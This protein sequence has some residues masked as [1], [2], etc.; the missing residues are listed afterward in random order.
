[1]SDVIARWERTAAIFSDRLHEVRDDQWGLP[2][3]CSEWNVR[4]LVDH[5]VGT[6]ARFGGV[7]GVEVAGA[8]WDHVR[9]AMSARLA[10]PDVLDATV[11]VPGLGPLPAEQIVEICVNDL[12]IHAW[13]LARS[14]GADETLPV[15]L[16]SACLTWL[17]ALPA[18][19]LR[20]GR[21]APAHTVDASASPQARML[22]FAGRQP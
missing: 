2:S 18:Q 21:Y 22:A 13:D 11:D 14:I 15:P 9:P 7:L 3:P 10:A 16:V 5:A 17:E 4:A 6:Q 19:V 8:G 1:L 20:S 12:L